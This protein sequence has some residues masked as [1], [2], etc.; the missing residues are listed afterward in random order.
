MFLDFKV[1]H[2]ECVMLDHKPIQILP[3][4]ISPRRNRPRRFE[5]VWLSENGCHEMVQAAWG[6]ELDRLMLKQVGEKNKDL[7]T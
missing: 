5:Q 7:P 2:L 6:A 1:I 3:S 4:G